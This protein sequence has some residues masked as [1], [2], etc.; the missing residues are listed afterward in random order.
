MYMLFEPS[1]SP[2]SLLPS[3]HPVKDLIN[4]NSGFSRKIH[5]IVYPA[6]SVRVFINP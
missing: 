3:P 4:T 2:C 1:S 5:V 6:Y